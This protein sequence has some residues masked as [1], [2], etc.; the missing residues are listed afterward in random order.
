MIVAGICGDLCGMSAFV[1]IVGGDGP[2]V[3]VIG[4]VGSGLER[5]LEKAMSLPSGDKRV[6]VVIVAEVIALAIFR[7]A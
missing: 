5:L 6:V 7:P 3:L 2:N 4:G 1:G